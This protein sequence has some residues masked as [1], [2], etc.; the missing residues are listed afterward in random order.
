MVCFP[1]KVVLVGDDVGGERGA[2][3]RAAKEGVGAR[4]SNGEHGIVPW[5]VENRQVGPRSAL[6]QWMR[7]RDEMFR[8]LVRVP[9]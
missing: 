1:L 4:E 9:E 6:R 3:P 5:P 2:K 7:R 8:A